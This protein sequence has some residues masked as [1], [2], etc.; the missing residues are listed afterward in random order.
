MRKEETNK[1][2]VDIDTLIENYKKKYEGYGGLC[3]SPPKSPGTID[4]N[5]FTAPKETGIN[6]DWKNTRMIREEKD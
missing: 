1:M 2:S 6:I 4:S 5:E 3:F